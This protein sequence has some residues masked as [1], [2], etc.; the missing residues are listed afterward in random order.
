MH[1]D[2]IPVSTATTPLTEWLNTDTACFLPHAGLLACEGP[3]SA[4]FL[5]G[6]LTCNVQD[7]SATQARYG[8]HCTPKGRMVANFLMLQ[9]QEQGY[10]LHTHHSVL[11]ALQKSLARYIVFSKATLRD[12][13]TDWVIVGLQGPTAGSRLTQLL[14]IPAPTGLL[15]QHRSDQGIVICLDEQTPRYEYWMPT[16]Q[17][18][19]LW[20]SL[21]THFAL[22]PAALWHW[23]D[24]RSGHAKVCDN[25]VEEFIPQMLNMEKTGGISFNKGCY[26]GQEIVARAHYRG[27][28]KK[29]MYRL[30][31][32]GQTPQPGD[33]LTSH[34]DD[35]MHTA[36]QWAATEYTGPNQ[37]EGLAV[38][39]H[40]DA[41]LPLHA[42]EEQPLQRLPLPYDDAERA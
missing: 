1:A 31:G 34:R 12:S 42:T 37:W 28:V 23:L 2:W 18:P 9:H 41:A 30:S 7:I 21:S 36:G 35:G 26:T 11:P 40:D 15:A 38:I 10:T 32:A 25:T 4:K 29:S 19:A 13:S 8:A 14:N 33:T 24:I 20:Q 39:Q 16:A 6:Q 3:D 27:A 22:A 17:A 5:Q